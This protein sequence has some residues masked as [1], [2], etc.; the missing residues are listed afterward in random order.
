MYFP[1]FNDVMTPP[2]PS[3]RGEKDGGTQKMV[4]N[5]KVRAHCG[6]TWN[7][8]EKLYEYAQWRYSA[9]PTTIYL[10]YFSKR[11]SRNYCWRSGAIWKSIRV[12][13]LSGVRRI[14]SRNLQPP[15][16]RVLMRAASRWISTWRVKP[17][18]KREIDGCI[19]RYLCAL[20]ETNAEVYLRE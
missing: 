6:R 10:P 7:L 3:I 4:I 8:Y 20:E 5:S 16:T 19:E 18:L 17:Q 1:C 14:H 13:Q 15:V 9:R 12:S 2:P 11:H